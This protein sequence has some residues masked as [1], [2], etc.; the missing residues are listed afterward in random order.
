MNT[1]AVLSF[2]I[3]LLLAACQAG[4]NTPP[5]WEEHPKAPQPSPPPPERA[6]SLAPIERIK[7]PRTGNE[8]YLRAYD[9]DYIVTVKEP[10]EAERYVTIEE[11]LM[12][13]ARLEAEWA[14]RNEDKKIDELRRRRR[15]IKER[16][17]YGFDEM[18][19][20]KEDVLQRK[21]DRLF[22]IQSQISA[23]E[24]TDQRPTE[25]AL[26]ITEQATLKEE[27]EQEQTALILL[28]H[29]KQTVDMLA[30]RRILNYDI[31]TIKANDLVARYTSTENFLKDLRDHT[32]ADWDRPPARMELSGN[33]LILVHDRAVLDRAMDYIKTLRKE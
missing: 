3:V 14:G 10:H 15:L 26:L 6:L 5:P 19:A 17:R 22:R 4:Q 1:K 12:F 18:I 30:D 16:D 25:M 28:R 9:Q 8:F 27:I 23:N 29:Q 33:Y 11:K 32:S 20:N 13:F 31:E 7:D 21:K 2:A 24:Q